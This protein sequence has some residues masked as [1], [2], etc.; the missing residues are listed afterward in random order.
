MKFGPKQAI[1]V[2]HHLMLSRFDE[3]R[4]LHR[5]RVFVAPRRHRKT[6]TAPHQTEIEMSPCHDDVQLGPAIADK[7][8]A[9]PSQRHCCARE[10]KSRKRVF[11]SVSIDIEWT[12]SYDDV[13]LNPVCLEAKHTRNKKPKRQQKQEEKNAFFFVCQCACVM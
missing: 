10:A 9:S 12:S 4:A 1:C 3:S 11:L 13:R 7:R 5:G 2:P 6:K 8:N